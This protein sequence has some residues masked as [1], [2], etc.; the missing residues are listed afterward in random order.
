MTIDEESYNT[1][2]SLVEETGICR[3]G[4]LQRKL[5]IGYARARVLADMM[6]ERGVVARPS[7]GS[8]DYSIINHGG[9]SDS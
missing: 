7:K 3:I 9:D 6:V 2:V 8:F 1:A 5:R 4:F